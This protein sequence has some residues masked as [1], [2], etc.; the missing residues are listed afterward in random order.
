MSLTRFDIDQ[1]FSRLQSGGLPTPPA[2]DAQNRLQIATEWV[3][4][5]G[6]G[7]T[8]DRLA[9][10]VTAYL[11][12]AARY[13]PTPGQL[14][15]LVVLPTPHG[16][17]IREPDPKD[18]D[19]YALRPGP[20]GPVVRRLQKVE[21]EWRHLALADEATCT[22][23]ACRCDAVRIACFTAH[24]FGAVFGRV[25]REHPP[26]RWVWAHHAAGLPGTAYRVVR[27]GA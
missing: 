18:W 9:G 5:L 25:L 23:P 4:A 14:L 8:P 3:K 26:E 12:S 21:G 7:M 13:W 17:S 1:A 6:A 15:A 27:T 11:R 24:A 10:A 2:W 19:W 22:D 16:S 20:E